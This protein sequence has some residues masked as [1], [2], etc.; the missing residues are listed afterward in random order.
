MADN[1]KPAPLA[2]RG[3]D[4]ALVQSDGLQRYMA[5]VARHP[6]LSREEE[7]ALARR[8][9]ADPEHNLDA[10]YTLVTA[11]LRLVVKIAHDYRRAAFS[12]LDLIQEGNIG[13]MQAVKKFDPTKGIKL[14]SYAA[15]WIRAYILRF[16]MDNFRMVK[17][18]TTEAQ[19]KL[20]FNLRKEQERLAQQ[21][22]EAGPKLL[23]ERLAVSEEDVVEMQARL[24]N[25]ELSLDL[26][27]SG[28]DSR[29]TQLDRLVSSS[30]P[31]DEQLGEAEV[32]ARF[33]EKLEE[34]A[35]GLEDKE[36]FIFEKRLV[37][38]EPLTLQ[39]IG[40][41]YQLTRERVRQ[42]EAKLTKRLRAYIA[43]EMPD[44]GDVSLSKLDK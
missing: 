43:A 27:A 8:Y 16:I 39:E 25:E 15:W 17:L 37:A 3:G 12:L 10:A 31:A 21:G 22:I 2:K 11:N 34:F 7:N 14:S 29:Q 38:E 13:L 40:D 28:E 6:L 44:L 42:I 9:F 41:E 26:P 23:A 30:A 24:G 18:G 4:A 36:R 20:F 35:K 19:R 33:H 32:R 5:E 1:R